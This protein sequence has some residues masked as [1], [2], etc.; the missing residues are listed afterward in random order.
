MMVIIEV[1]GLPIEPTRAVWP[2]KLYT[3]AKH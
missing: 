3:V 2:Q 1:G